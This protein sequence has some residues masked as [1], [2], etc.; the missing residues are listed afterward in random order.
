[1]Y[2]YMAYTGIKHVLILQMYI[3]IFI[4]PLLKMYG[5]CIAFDMYL[6]IHIFKYVCMYIQITHV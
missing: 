2:V 6:Y 3:C 5:E 1:M 4:F